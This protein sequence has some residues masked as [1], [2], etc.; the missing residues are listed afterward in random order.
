MFGVGFWLKDFEK[1]I[2][3]K[4]I[5]ILI[6]NLLMK[7]ILRSSNKFEK[8]E[9]IRDYQILNGIGRKALLEAFNNLKIDSLVFSD[10][11]D[12]N[13][14][15]I[16]NFSNNNSIKSLCLNSCDFSTN[17]TEIWNLLVKNKSITSLDLSENEFIKS[18]FEIIIESLNTN[19]TL[20]TLILNQIEI[21]FTS[22]GKMIAKLLRNN[23]TLKRL[24]LNKNVITF[25]C[26][27]AI[28][29][30]LCEN[31]SLTHLDISYNS[32]DYRNCLMLKTMLQK[33][34]TLI[35]LNLSHNSLGES[36]TEI[37]SA[38]CE[39]T[40]LTHLDISYNS[41]D[42]R[43]CFMLKTML[44]ENTNLISLDLSHNSLGD[45]G[46]L[47][48]EG[49]YKNTNLQFLFLLNN[50]FTIEI[51][52]PFVDCLLINT[53][54]ISL[55]LSYFSELETKDKLQIQLCLKQDKYVN[56]RERIIIYDFEKDLGIRNLSSPYRTK[57]R[58]QTL[59]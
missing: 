7:M 5:A 3:N 40:S 36:G 57:I 53:T 4:Q 20:T 41:L 10:C 15:T 8:L 50:K 1:I 24:R 54:L 37:F 34:T 27:N 11:L 51:F 19:K 17:H 43:N 58:Y 47:I 56:V 18:Q 6:T 33:N 42:S 16:A 55:D 14:E 26:G 59:C 38:L 44:Q 45:S 9:L 2:E 23:K 46:H 49:L 12:I 35:S 32:L 21:E 28:F 25:E 29:S 52:K 48:A 22:I 30:A 13:I 39:N 31:T